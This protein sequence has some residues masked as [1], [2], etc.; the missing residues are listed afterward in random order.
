M[1]SATFTFKPYKGPLLQKVAHW[2]Q[3]SVALKIPLQSAPLER[4]QTGGEN[5]V[6]REA[7]WI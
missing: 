5:M 3:A 6:Q 1:S 7:A 4:Q 2:Y